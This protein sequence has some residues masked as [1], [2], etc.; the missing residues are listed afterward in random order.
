MATSSSLPKIS[1]RIEKE[2]YHTKVV[3]R[4]LPPNFTEENFHELFSPLPPYNYFYFSPGDPSLGMFG[5]ARAYLDFVDESTIMPFRNEHDGRIL[6]AEKGK[7][8]RVVME[9]A[10]FQSVP[11]M[12]TR[13]Q[14]ARCAT[15]EQD[16]DYMAFLE[17]LDSKPESLPSAEHLDSRQTSKASSVQKTPLIEYLVERKAAKAARAS[18]KNKVYVVEKKRKG[19]PFKDRKSSSEDSFS[20]SKNSKRHGFGR[21]EEARKGKR[22][23]KTEES[24]S[25]VKLTSQ[26]QEER[27]SNH[28]KHGG[29]GG[30]KDS[31]YQP[32]SR[33]REDEGK[34][35]QERKT[36][37]NPRRQDNDEGSEDVEKS[38]SRDRPDRAIYVPRSSGKSRGTENDYT[39]TD[40][41]YPGRTKRDYS[42]SK[43]DRDDARIDNETK[44]RSFDSGSRFYSDDYG[45]QDK[46][47]R[48]R[49]KGE[50][51]NDDRDR[52]WVG[53]PRDR[54]YRGRGRGYRFDS[55]DKQKT[56]SHQDR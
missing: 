47:G 45:R 38:H 21:G 27:M 51:Y 32:A 7:K 43:Y 56:S 6:E 22:E 54:S 10:P 52:E 37:A 34:R 20:S 19:D 3:V 1:K 8:Y 17:S 5:C 36:S 42:S 35:G 9:Y 46:R 26:D 53:K 48:G 31:R 28:V 18:K 33:E 16:T 39:R 40:R 41:D 15:I 12:T 44:D 11:K 4:R 55:Y 2:L 50:R 13:K 49:G 25:A 14:D 29:G 23:G 30:Y 24:A